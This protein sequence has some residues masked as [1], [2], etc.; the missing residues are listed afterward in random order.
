[1]ASLIPLQDAQQIV[2]S[3]VSAGPTVRVPLRAAVNR[4]LA[5]AVACDLDH[6]P[7]DRSLMDG[8][9][10]RSADLGSMPATLDV[11]G[12]VTA[13]SE[14][15]VPVGP[16]Q[17]IQ[18]CTGAPVPPGC[19]AVV[20]VED[21]ERRAERVTIKVGTAPGRYIATRASSVRAG[22]TVLEPG[23]RLSPA[24]IA[25]VAACGH[26]SVSVYQQ[27]SVALLVTGNE[28]VEPDRKPAGAQI[29]DS[30][31]FVLDALVRQA[32]CRPVDLGV[33]R[34]DPKVL[35]ERLGRG[36][37]TGFLCTAG[38]VSMGEFDF[39][40]RCLQECG[41]TI[42]FHRVAIKPGKPVLFATTADGGYVFGLPGNPV[43]VFTTF[44]LLVRPALALRQGRSDVL[45]RA[46]SVRLAKP[47]GATG[48]RR[49]FR[50]A[51]VEP[52]RDGRLTAE[53]LVVRGSGDLFGMARANALIETAPHTPAQPQGQEARA[54]LL[55][56][57]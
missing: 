1:M 24:Q 31:R 30:N 46:V 27:P 25:I 16:G 19:D 54:V 15:D 39:V 35:T 41:A 13:G 37:A 22:Q 21:T 29:R 9:A 20:R 18:I 47:I 34:D 49:T 57:P 17:A 6:P 43:S 45:P 48:D 26:S 44:W 38:G 51:R 28:L 3:T 7:F 55:E 2:L 56:G 4:T 12:R 33:A 50:P 40:P 10:V 11:V 14:A 8:Y 32:H 36:L 5:E 53:P 42:R 52:D 23:R